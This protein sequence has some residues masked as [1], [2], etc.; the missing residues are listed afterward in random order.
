MPCNEPPAEDIASQSVLKEALMNRDNFWLPDE[1]FSK[2]APRLPT[3]ARG[4]AHV[5]K[6]V[7]GWLFVR[8]RAA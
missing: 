6:L 2:I 1:Q 4:K 8:M 5:K 3:H 7:K